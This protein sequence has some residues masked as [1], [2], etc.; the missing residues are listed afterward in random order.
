MGRREGEL[1]FGDGRGILVPSRLS[2]GS[3]NW[4]L[5]ESDIVDM[6]YWFCIAVSNCDS[7]VGER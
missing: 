4:Q 7:S 1:V 6:S 3:Q 2:G 5:G